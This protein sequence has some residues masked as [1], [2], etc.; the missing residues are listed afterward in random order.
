MFTPH[1]ATGGEQ[2]VP[3]GEHGLFANKL[4]FPVTK[5]TLPVA[6]QETPKCFPGL[7]PSVPDQETNFSE[8]V[9]S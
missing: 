4:T 2:E 7:T 6:P 1:T 3:T 9:N 8:A 5:A